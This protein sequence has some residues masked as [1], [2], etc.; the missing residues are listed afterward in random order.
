MS[1]VLPTAA[2][3]IRAYEAR[4]NKPAEPPEE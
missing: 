1:L 2:G 3:P 4:K